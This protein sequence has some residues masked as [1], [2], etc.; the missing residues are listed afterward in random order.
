MKKWLKNPNFYL[1]C[2][3]VIGAIL[4][5]YSLDRS[6]VL[7]DEASMTFRSIG[8][9]DWLATP[10]QTT[11]L[12][13]LSYR[14][15]WLYLSFHDHP[16]FSFFLQ[17]IQLSLTGVSIWAMR[18]WP[19]LYGCISIWLT[20]L[21]GK[22]MFGQTSGILAAS[23][24]AVGNLPIWISRL[25]LQESLTL[26]LIL[27]SFLFFLNALENKKYFYL[28]GL[29]IGLAMA[30]KLTAIIVWPTILIYLIIFQR[31]FFRSREIYFSLLISAIFLLPN[32]I[33]NIFLYQNFG[34]YDFQISY[35]LNQSVDAWQIRPGRAEIPDKSMAFGFMF[36]GLQKS[37]S[38][39]SLT[40]FLLSLLG[41]LWYFV[42]NKFRNI[43][44][45]YWLL[46]IIV[47]MH[48]VLYVAIGSAVRFLALLMPWV[49]IASALL[50][51]K[52]VKIK[53]IGY[54]LLTIFLAY[55]I[56]FSYN[57][58]ISYAY[59]GRPGLGYSELK[60]QVYAYGYNRLIK[61][62]DELVA[63]KKPAVSLPVVNKNISDYIKNNVEEADGLAT[64]IMMVYD[65]RF[66][67]EP[68]VWGLT[69]H[70]LYGGWPVLHLDTYLDAVEQN[71]P[72]LFDSMGLKD[73][74]FI[75]AT[76]NTAVDTAVSQQ[77]VD[78][79]KKFM[80]DNQD[81]LILIDTI[82]DRNQKEIFRIYKISK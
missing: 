71:G 36:S 17:H 40:V 6:D 26:M 72:E 15:W 76:E 22:K 32:I 24:L 69:R 19:A 74:Y 30:T 79:Q 43:P 38:P 34:H 45:Y 12:E 16:F 50:F 65:P 62:V 18:F 52:I 23:L 61:Y 73:I 31:H 29:G 5:F 4:R 68:I 54:G 55:E 60:H 75:M 57:T 27:L 1:I 28:L 35:L 13:W 59:T 48:I 49:A 39:I 41:G 67:G 11:P 66:Y 56:F 33:Y 64:P 80:E 81:I 47:L 46:T 8:Y 9:F 44:S 25:A 70:F 14:P 37:M 63:G 53:Y 21:I 10:Y 82:Y 51:K 3:L 2:F 77:S 7:T 20:Y 58:N 78:R 42:K